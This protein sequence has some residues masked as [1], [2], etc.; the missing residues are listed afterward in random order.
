MRIDSIIFF[1]DGDVVG[2]GGDDGGGATNAV[3]KIV[4]YCEIGLWNL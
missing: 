4:F 2:G 3:S 1:A